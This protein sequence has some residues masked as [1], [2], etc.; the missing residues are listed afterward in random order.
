MAPSTSGQQF[1]CSQITYEITVYCIGFVSQASTDQNDDS[2]AAKH[3]K[4]SSIF[5]ASMAGIAS[6]L[7]LVG[8]IT[9][10]WVTVE[11]GLFTV[12]VGVFRSCISGLGICVS[13]ISG[14]ITLSTPVFFKNYK[15]SGIQCICCY[16]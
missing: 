6:V 14:I 1:D 10:T 12:H 9:P 16:T 2:G 11:T 13:S 7:L 4:V 5:G 3:I 15:I 8:Y